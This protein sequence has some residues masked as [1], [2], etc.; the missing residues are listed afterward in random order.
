MSAADLVEPGDVV[1]LKSGGPNMLVLGRDPGEDYRTLCAWAAYIDGNPGT[2]FAN[3]DP[4]ALVLLLKGDSLH[5]EQ[6]RDAMQRAMELE[7]RIGKVHALLMDVSADPRRVLEQIAVAVGATF[8]HAT[9]QE[10]E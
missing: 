5:L 8:F 2:R 1:R 9:E 4:R 6:Y 7:A 10:T 3:F